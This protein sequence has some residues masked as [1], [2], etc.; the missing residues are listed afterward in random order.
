MESGWTA[1]WQNLGDLLALSP[2]PRQVVRQTSP[3][4]EMLHAAHAM[5]QFE[6][7][8]EV[9]NALGP[10]AESS[11]PTHLARALLLQDEAETVGE[12]VKNQWMENHGVLLLWCPNY[13]SLLI[14]QSG[15]VMVR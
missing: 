13:V 2:T 14:Q 1:R 10:F 11:D 7:E 15:Y 12:M 9:A 6:A 4:R 3:K 5:E 8:D